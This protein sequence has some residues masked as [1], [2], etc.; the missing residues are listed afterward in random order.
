MAGNGGMQYEEQG[1]ELDPKY[2][3]SYVA[4]GSVDAETRGGHLQIRNQDEADMT[5][6][7][8]E[9]TGYREDHASYKN[10]SREDDSHVQG[11][12]RKRDWAGS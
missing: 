10:L 11:E 1:E 12:Y 6:A 4:P 7:I 5:A 2:R 8:I 9:A 3:M